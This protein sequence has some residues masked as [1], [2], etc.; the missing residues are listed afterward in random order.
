MNDP[1]DNAADDRN[2]LDRLGAA[3]AQVAARFAA[4]TNPDLD[5][6]LR[7][8]EDLPE[9]V[10]MAAGDLAAVQ[11]LAALRDALR[12]LQTGGLDED[13]IEEFCSWALHADPA[14]PNVAG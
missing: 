14:N 12:A 6:A 10:L 9:A 2:I 5:G 7:R 3:N 1:H 13:R 8:T 11:Q 4:D